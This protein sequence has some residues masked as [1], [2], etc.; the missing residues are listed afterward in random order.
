MAVRITCINKAHGNHNNPHEAIEK[1]GWV[2]EFSGESGICSRLDMVRFIENEKGVAYVIDRYG[3]K[4]YLYVRASVNGNK[5]V[6]T[7]ADGK[8]SDNLLALIECRR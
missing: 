2:N 6:Q 3:N 1:L 8:Y 5:F 7:I 4:A